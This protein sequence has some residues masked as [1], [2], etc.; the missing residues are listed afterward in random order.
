MVMAERYEQC[1][2]ALEMAPDVDHFG[3]ILLLMII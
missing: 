2:G 3:D 1:D